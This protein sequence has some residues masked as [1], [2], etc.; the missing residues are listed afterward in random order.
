MTDEHDDRRKT[1]PPDFVRYL[2][3]RSAS[4]VSFAP[5]G[6]RIAFL[7][8]ITDV[9]E[10]WS[11]AV[12][13]GT[14]HAQKNTG[15]ALPWPEQLTFGGE[16]TVGAAFSPVADQLIVGSDVGG[17]ERTQLFLLSGD[18]AVTGTTLTPLTSQP[19]AIHVL[20]WLAGGWLLQQRLVARWRMH[21]LCEQRP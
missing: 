10:V 2:N 4:G 3:V 12:P 18:G 14:S 19:D 7:T 16:R 15:E 20:R 11:V 1:T 8:D 17:N 6:L 13:K 5:D 9:A 21:R